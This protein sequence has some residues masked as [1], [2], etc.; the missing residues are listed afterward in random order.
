MKPF[1]EF[2]DSLSEDDITA[3]ADVANE[4]AQ[5]VNPEDPDHLLGTQIGV[6]NTMMTMQLLNRYHDW[7]SEQL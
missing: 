7:I 6:I 2:W 3:M 1:S 5:S 4:R